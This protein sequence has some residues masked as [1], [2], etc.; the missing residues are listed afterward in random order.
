M[1]LVLFFGTIST[2][3]MTWIS[4]S[5]AIV[6]FSFFFFSPPTQHCCRQ[7]STQPRPSLAAEQMNSSTTNVTRHL[8]D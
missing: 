8:K 6:S 7:G 4:Y 2:V 3:A 5:S 1:V